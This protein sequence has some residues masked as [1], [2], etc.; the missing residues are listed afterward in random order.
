MHQLFI[1]D[2]HLEEERPDTLQ[3]F[4]HFLQ[5]DAPSADELYILGDFFEFWIGD[6]DDRPLVDEIS[7]ALERL[8]RS[9]THIFIMRGNRDFLLGEDFC[10]R[11]GATLLEDPTVITVAGEPCLLLHGDS[12]C[13]RDE[14]YMAFRAQSRTPQWKAAAL[15]KPL[16]ERRIIAKQMR[17]ASNEAT[18]NNAE[19]I[20]DVTPD[21]VIAVLAQHNCQR[22][23]HGHTHRPHRHSI[24]VNGQPAERIVLG[25]WDQ[26]LWYLAVD[27]QDIELHHRKITS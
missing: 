23:I 5:N 25:D 24:S 27:G 22:M 9:G 19:D 12:L 6:D 13:T 3:A 15:A 21:E 26:H 7:S 11:A 18:S 4:F 17:I 8:S 14:K 1:S 10:R 16:E 20:M 2:L